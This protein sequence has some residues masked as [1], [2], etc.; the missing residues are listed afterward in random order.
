MSSGLMTQEHR[1]ILR[2]SRMLLARKCQDQISP[3]CE[4]LFEANILTSY[5]KQIIES[6]STAFEKVCTLLDILPERGDRA[7]DE[8]CDALTYC[9]ITVE[10]FNSGRKPKNSK[11]IKKDTESETSQQEGIAIQNDMDPI[12]DDLKRPDIFIDIADNAKSIKVIE[13]GR[14]LRLSNNDVDD[15]ANSNGNR[16]DKFIHLLEEWYSQFASAATFDKLLDAL[17]SCNEVVVAEKLK[18]K[19]SI[20]SKS[21]GRKPK[22]SK[23]IKKNTEYS[24]LEF[25][26]AHKHRKTI[27]PIIIKDVDPKKDLI[28]SDG[29]RDFYVLVSGKVYTK[30]LRQKQTDDEFKKKL[31]KL[32]ESIVKPKPETKSSQQQL[33]PAKDEVDKMDTETAPG[34][35]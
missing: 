28:S 18:K 29:E 15:L 1:E 9:E 6:K 27:K 14:K 31:E 24:Y 32:Y 13:L 12:Q 35:L 33:S 10:N 11:D 17:R 34:K 30:I 2:A 16:F 7:F 5:H 8:F 21:G 26:Y 25:N 19:Y 20:S 23:D 22:N 4:C 3:I